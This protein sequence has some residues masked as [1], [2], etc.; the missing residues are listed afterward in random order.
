MT[1][2]RPTQADVAKRAGVSR[3]TVSMVLSGH[4]GRVPI[5]EETRRRVLQAVSEMGYAPNPAAQM[6]AQGR[7]R[8]IGVFTYEPVFPYSGD[9]FYYP[10]LLGIEHEA[11]RQDYNVLL[12]TRNRSAG[13]RSIYGQG[14]NALAIADG[15]LLLG[16]RPDRSELKRLYEEGYPFVFIGRREVPGCEIDWV[17]SDYITA[18]A[19][20]TRHLIELGHRRLA[21]VGEGSDEAQ[22]DR[23]AGC[24][25]AVAQAGGVELQVLPRELLH[26]PDE[27]LAALRQAGATAVLFNTIAASVAADLLGKSARVPEELSIVILNDADWHGLSPWRPTHTRLNRQT[28]GEVALRTLVARLDGQAVGPQ[29]IRV[30]CDLIIGNTTAPPRSG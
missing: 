1:N 23:L 9:D 29:Q 12:F 16:P 27:F 5:S 28:V 13:L 22:V 2:R 19:D 20:A 10:F 21:Y 26:R 24:R 18:S 25:S 17:V 11:S 7:N 14:A 15:A 3:G 4:S 8:L 30:P 6:L